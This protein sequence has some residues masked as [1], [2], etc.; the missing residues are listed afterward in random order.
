MSRHCEE[1]LRRSNPSFEFAARWI[2]CAPG[3]LALSSR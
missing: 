1:R 2:A 3:K